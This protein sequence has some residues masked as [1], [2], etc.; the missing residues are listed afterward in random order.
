MFTEKDFEVLKKEA[1]KECYLYTVRD[2]IRIDDFFHQLHPELT[3]SKIRK[4]IKEGQVT[5]D[6]ETVKPNKK[7]HKGNKIDIDL[8]RP[9]TNLPVKENLNLEIIFEDEYLAVINKPPG[10]VVHPA[11]GNYEGTIVSGLL[12][13]FDELAASKEKTR[14]GIVHRLDKETSGV[15]LIAKTDEAH[16]KL[17]AL[18]KDRKMRKVYQGIVYGKLKEKKGVVN[19]PIGRSLSDRTKMAVRYDNSREAIT[20]YQVLQESENHDFSLI[21][22]YPKTGRTHQIRI[23]AK[24]LNCPIAGDKKYLKG[25]YPFQSTISRHLLHARSLSFIHPFT[26]KELSFTANHFDDFLHLQEK[27]FHSSTIV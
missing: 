6:G 27:I 3:L 21:E 17:S 25:K 11:P 12:Y 5:I 2:S 14:V 13:Y 20:A 15:L 4:I 22:F 19:E 7:L 9:E 24:F 1:E 8:H 10:I 26:Q 23:H 18:F 16:E